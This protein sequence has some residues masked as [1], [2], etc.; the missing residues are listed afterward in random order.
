MNIPFS[1]PDITELEIHEVVE[2]LQSGWITTGARTKELERQIAEYIGLPKCVCLNS[3]TAAMEMTLRVLGIGPGDEV[4]TSAY[5]Y[6]ATASVIDHVG[7]KIVLVDTMADSFEINYDQ[8]EEAINEKTKAIIP[9]DIGGRLCNYERLQEIVEKKKDLF[10]PGSPLQE[11]FGRV[12]LI[13]DSAHGFGAQYKGVRSGNFA[14]FTNFSF[15]A[16]KN[17]TTGEGGAVV[18]KE[19]EGLDN[20]ALYKEYMLFSLH[21]QSKDALAKTKLGSW[22]YDIVYPAYKCNMTDLQAAIGLKQMERYDKLLKRRAEIIKKYD[23]TVLSQ[24]WKRLEHFDDNNQSSGHLY[25]LR[26]P[27]IGE[28]ERNRIITGMGEAGIA[29]NV[30]YKPL[31]MMTAYSKMGFKMEDFPNAFAQYENEITLPL[32]TKLTDAEVAYICDHLV[33]VVGEVMKG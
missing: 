30:H 11:V 6:T 14:D 12:I 8:V 23:E 20:D 31:P 24:G 9:V 21:G 15:H 25:L 13:A 29:T 28:E 18:W 26:I 10:T 17:F 2:A 19:V 4:I 3:A 32:H 5:T 7:A 16:V 33:T 27:G 1:P 22:E